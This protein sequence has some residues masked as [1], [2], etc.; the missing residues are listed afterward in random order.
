M[1]CAVCIR[2]MMSFCSLGAGCSLST[3]LINRNPFLQPGFVDALV[4]TWTDSPCST[5][6]LIEH[7]LVRPVAHK[8]DVPFSRHVP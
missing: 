1:F 7:F 5:A 4:K 2:K 3:I 8:Q 6:A